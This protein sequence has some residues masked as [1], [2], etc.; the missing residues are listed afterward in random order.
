MGICPKCKHEVDNE[1]PPHLYAFEAVIKKASGMDSAAGHDGADI[2][3][4]IRDT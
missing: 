3:F 2:S 4:W 1:P